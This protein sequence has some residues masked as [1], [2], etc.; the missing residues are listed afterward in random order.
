LD[1][2]YKNSNKL[3]SIILREECAIVRMIIALK[4]NALEFMF[5]GPCTKNLILF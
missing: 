4:V 1:D 2:N 5:H 3:L